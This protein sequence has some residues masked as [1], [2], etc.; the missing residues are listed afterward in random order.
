[1]T[2][3]ESKVIGIKPHF[4]LLLP[5]C[6]FMYRRYINY[7]DYATSKKEQSRISGKGL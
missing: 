4:T 7:P 5:I 6:Y 3:S 1:M 2:E